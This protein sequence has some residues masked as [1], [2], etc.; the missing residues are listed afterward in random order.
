M[1]IVLARTTN[2]TL[3]EAPSLDQNTISPLK[4]KL[5][6]SLKDF[7]FREGTTKIT[8]LE[9]N[10]KSEQG[11]LIISE[12]IHMSLVKNFENRFSNKKSKNLRF[13]LCLLAKN[14]LFSNVFLVSSSNFFTCICSDAPDR[15]FRKTGMTPE[16]E[17]KRMTFLAFSYLIE[18]C[19]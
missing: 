16:E 4:K 14:L 13:S 7:R 12:G 1:G 9:S 5:Y 19:L 3:Q 10:S 17:C 11:I 2:I 6:Q 15:K 18:I 8:S